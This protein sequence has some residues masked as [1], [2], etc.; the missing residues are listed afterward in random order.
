MNEEVIKQSFKLREEYRHG[1]INLPGRFANS[2]H[3]ECATK[4]AEKSS[5]Q[6]F[7]KSIIFLQNKTITVQYILKTHV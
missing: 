7:Y 2:I 1:K 3:Y 6:L 4:K 5:P